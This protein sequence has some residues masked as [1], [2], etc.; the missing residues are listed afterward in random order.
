MKYTRKYL[1]LFGILLSFTAFL[2]VLPLILEHQVA[3]QLE[4]ILK[5][6]VLLDDVDLNLFTLELRLEK[7]EIQEAISDKPFIAFDEF[8]L[9]ASWLSLFRLAVVVD[10]IYLKQP[11]FQGVML[12]DNTFNFS[13]LAAPTA[14]PLSKTTAVAKSEKKDLSLDQLPVSFD[15]K[16][17]EI[18]D[19]S[20]LF[21]DHVHEKTHKLKELNFNVP[22]ITNVLKASENPT[23]ITLNFSIND[24]KVKIQTQAHIF[25][26]IPSIKINFKNS[27]GDFSFYQPY[28]SKILDWKISSGELKTNLGLDVKLINNT[29][30][31]MIQGNVQIVNFELKENKQHPLISF[32]LLEVHIDKSHLLK[33]HVNLSLV[34]W[35]QPKIQVTRR[36]DQSLNWIPVLKKSHSQKSVKKKK[37]VASSEL[38]TKKIS[39]SKKE[40]AIDIQIQKVQLEKGLIS[41]KDNSLSKPFET[42]L[43][44]LNLTLA[45]INLRDQIIPS[46]EFQTELLP[47]GKISLKGSANLAPL[48]WKGNISIKDLDIS[49][50]QPYLNEFLNGRLESGRLFIELDTSFEQKNKNPQVQLSGKLALNHVVYREPMNMEEVLSW[51]KF[52]IIKLN[53]GI[54]PHYVDIDEVRLESFKAPVFLLADGKLN[55]LAIMKNQDANTPAAKSSVAES[56]QITQ[57]T[58]SVKSSKTLP[59]ENKSLSPL[60]RFKIRKVVMEDSAIRFV[61]QTMKPAFQAQMTNLNGQV[62]GIDQEMSSSANF[63]FNGKLNDLSPLQIVGRISPFQ[64]P[65]SLK[66]EILFQGIE[67]P[68]FTPYTHH[69]IGYPLDKG[70]LTLNLDYQVERNELN[71]V[72][73]VV[74]NQLELGEKNENAEIPSLP[75]EFA[76]AILKDREGKIKIDIPVNGK[77]D[78]L[79]FSLKKVILQTLKNTIEKIVTSPFTFLTQLFGGKEDIQSLVFDYGKT[80]LKKSTQLKLEQ[81][82][83]L[84]VSRP[85]LK[86]QLLSHLNKHKESKELKKVRLQKELELLKFKEKT[87]QSESD[88]KIEHVVLTEKE[89]EQYLIKLYQLR[90]NKMPAFKYQNRRSLEPTLS[91][92]IEVV[93]EDLEALSLKRMVHVRNILVDKYKI[94]ADRIFIRERNVKADALPKN[95]QSQILLKLQ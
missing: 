93:P 71:S 70:Q 20:I 69:Y 72:N 21:E 82:A 64:N 53:S 33:P 37:A 63:L 44:N 56:S 10:Q 18:Q 22:Q 41:I 91:S 11:F 86:L 68:L 60:Q 65:L 67:V 27:G 45:S 32:P 23:E 5:R 80:D 1:W 24:C 52:E 61:D 90:F 4:S 15:I 14:S 6:N 88:E 7:F 3:Y 87:T 40:S 9:N 8:Y 79:N 75:L 95:S 92:T 12:S 25:Q 35:V 76:L 19:G 28:L 13:D 50:A 49:M 55:W 57:L 59:S 84:L 58:A 66:V 83:K 74:L 17:I 51:D 78:S 46:I 36:K 29:P 26:K 73:K 47:H 81:V 85:L 30:D 2:I 34:K 94:Q 43:K 16:N 42:Q 39:N 48:K 38:N 31:L 62:L 89:Y 77:L 54:F